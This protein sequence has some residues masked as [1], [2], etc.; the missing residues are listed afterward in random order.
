MTSS[1]ENFQEGEDFAQYVKVPHERIAIIIGKKGE[2]KSELEKELNVTINVD[3][4]EGDIQIKS[5][6]SFKLM[7][8]KD[9]I[10]A[11]A[12][13]FNPDIAKK[14]I[15]EDYFLELINLNDYNPHK[16]HQQ[17]L[18]GRVIGREGRSRALI[19]EYTGCYVSVYG[20]TIGIIGKGDAVRIANKAVDS[21][22]TGS[23]HAYVYK[24]L[25]K[26]RNNLMGMGGPA[27]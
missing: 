19:E 5:D 2:T 24:W 10:K 1:I 22:L 4:T 6:D 27:F 8:A 7:I 18:K 11:I 17:R 15:Q 23:P 3:S 26:E 12:R 25:E 13:G 21:L 20:K 9:V 14:L 16:N